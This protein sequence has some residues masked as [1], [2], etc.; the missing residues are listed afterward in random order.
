[1]KWHTYEK[2][3]ATAIEYIATH[4][5]NRVETIDTKYAIE[6]NFIRIKSELESRQQDAIER[7]KST[8]G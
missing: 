3:D 8:Y 6:I 4:M 7:C 5:L 1:M 2:I